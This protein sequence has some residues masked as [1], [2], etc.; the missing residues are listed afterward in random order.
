MSQP[1]EA[2]HHQL[3]AISGTMAAWLSESTPQNPDWSPNQWQTFKM[4]CRVHGVAPLL[5]EKLRQ[6]KWLEPDV[7]VWLAEQYQ[8]NARRLAKIHQELD[9]ILG[10]FQQNNVP[11]IPL[12]GSVLSTNVYKDPAWRPMADL[13]IL[14]HPGDFERSSKLLKQLGYE[15]GVAHWKHTEF[16]KPD[17]RSVVS[18]TVEHPDNPRGVE[19]HR[20]CRETFAGPTIDLTEMMWDSAHPGQLRGQPALLTSPDLLWLHLVVHATYHAWQGRGR[21]IHLVDLAYLTPRLGQIEPLLK[22][23]EA[24]FIYPALKLLDQYFP[25]VLAPSILADQRQRTSAP[26][27]KW[28]AA[29]DL[30]NT[31]YLNPR[32]A[33]LYLFKALRFSEGRPQD[34]VQALRF[35]FL[36]S[37]EE[38]ALDHPRLAASKLAWVGYFLLPLDWIRRFVEKNPR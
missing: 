5:H 22:Q 24:R 10:L 8:F 37:L 23:V 12:K 18:K 25:S 21:L 9:D 4:A 30:V 3:E 38:I 2:R 36:P 26:F 16:I 28:V 19:L 35:A 13:D 7:K 17:N 14:I 33:G 29:L 6:A 11:V 31:S 32:P 34:V 20:Y 27:Q 15:P 1:V